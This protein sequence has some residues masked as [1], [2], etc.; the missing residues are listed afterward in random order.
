MSEKILMDSGYL[1]THI[2]LRLTFLGC[3]NGDGRKKDGAEQ[4][5]YC[6]KGGP[7]DTI[8]GQ[9]IDSIMVHL[10]GSHACDS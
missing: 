3:Y 6:G 8:L 10:R 9:S 4:E 7:E 1:Y 2:W 5:G